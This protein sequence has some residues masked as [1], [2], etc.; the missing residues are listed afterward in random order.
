MAE[1]RQRAHLLFH[2]IGKYHNESPFI[3]PI[4]GWSELAQ[5]FARKAAVLGAQCMLHTSLVSEEFKANLEDDSENV[6]ALT[7]DNDTRWNAKK[8]VRSTEISKKLF[9]SWQF[10]LDFRDNEKLLSEDSFFLVMPPS[11]SSQLLEGNPAYLMCLPEAFFPG[12]RGTGSSVISNHCFLWTLDVL[13]TSEICF[14]LS[15]AGITNFETVHASVPFSTDLLN[16]QPIE[17]TNDMSC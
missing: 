7:F 2:S 14:F 13:N 9:Y 15:L 17:S 6:H 8:V 1:A 5:G 16:I 4:Y 10:H 3:F 12:Q 11:V